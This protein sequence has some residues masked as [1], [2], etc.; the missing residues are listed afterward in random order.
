LPSPTFVA[1]YPC[2]SFT[3][4]TSPKTSS[5]TVANGDVLAVV[6]VADGPGRT[7]TPSGGGLT[8]TQRAL[9]NTTSFGY[10][11]VFIAESNSAQSF[12]LS[13]TDTGGTQWGF[14]AIRF[15]SARDAANG[16]GTTVASSNNGYVTLVTAN[17]NSSVVSGI[18]DFNAPVVGASHAWL[19]DATTAG[20]QL[21]YAQSSPNYTYGIGYFTDA[22]TAASHTFGLQNNSNV[23]SAAGVA[24]AAVKFQS[25]SAAAIKL[26]N[27][28]QA[29]QRAAVR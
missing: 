17:A 4:T 27:V 5:V 22:G 16:A 21:D 23:W 10:V 24:A 26:T 29:R 15:S 12:T 18:S 8:Y 2:A 14:E 20:T 13:I 28:T 3:T 11:A 19:E 6:V 1:S 7:I 25:P 9:V